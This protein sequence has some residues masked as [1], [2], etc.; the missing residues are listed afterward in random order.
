ME[1]SS[2]PI[3]N[4]AELPTPTLVLN[5]ERITQNLQRMIAMAGHPQRLRPHIKTHKLPQLIYQQLDLGIRQFKCATIAEA[6]MAALS[7]APDILLAAQPVGTNAMR[8]VQLIER[9]EQVH[10]IALVDDEGA[11][12]VL[13]ELASVP[14]V[15]MSLMVDLNVGQN[16]SGILPDERAFRLYQAIA[17]HDDLRTMGLHAYDGHLTQSDPAERREACAAAFAPVWKLRQSLLEAGYEVPEVVA[18]GSP[19]FPLHA[20]NALATCSPGTTVLWDAGYAEKFPDLDFQPA[21]QLVA[22]VISKP[23]PNRLCLDLGHKAVASEMPQPRVFF[24][25]WPEAVAVLHNEE[26]LVIETERAHECALGEIIFGYPRHIC[27][28]VALHSE[29][30]VCRDGEVTEAW[31]VVGRTRRLGV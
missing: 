17:E 29:V 16:R 18:G 24:P 2:F 10:F 23:T 25:A 5:A 30:W 20:E 15:E 26:H 19:T 13:G 11:L 28:T 31:P 12:Q 3:H 22:R 21:A 1:L 4:A 8:W 7:G 27:P 14:G 6:E 9:F